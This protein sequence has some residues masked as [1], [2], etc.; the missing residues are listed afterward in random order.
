M[1]VGLGYFPVFAATVYYDIGEI[2]L[3]LASVSSF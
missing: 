3:L 2:N 1:S